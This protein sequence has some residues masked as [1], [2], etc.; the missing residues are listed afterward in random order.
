MSGDFSLSLKAFEDR[1]N[2]YMDDVL[3]KVAVDVLAR[4]VLKS[5]VGN[6]DL[7]KIPVKGYVGGRFRSA[8]YV[9]QSGIAINY[10]FITTIDP[11]GQRTIARAVNVLR[12]FKAGE[13]IVIHN[14]MP[15]GQRL[16]HGWS[17]QAPAGM[18]K[19][20]LAEFDSVFRAAKGA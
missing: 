4:V 14:P 15:Y 13:R 16:E 10:E 20:T 11:D 5:P 7:W 3:R 8:W 12:T 2:V 19:V 6:P 9:Q 18:V 1:A 17:T